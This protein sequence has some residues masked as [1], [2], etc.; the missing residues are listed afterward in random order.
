MSQRINWWLIPDL[1]WPRT[2]GMGCASRILLALMS[3]LLSQAAW[4]A[5]NL[6]GTSSTV[7]TVSAEQD[8]GYLNSRS[9]TFDRLEPQ[10]SSMSIPMYGDSITEAMDASQIGPHVVLM[11][12]NG[13]T[14]RDWF[15]RVNR[16]LV[17]GPAVIHSSQ[18]G[19]WALGINDTQYEY[20]TGAPQN[21]PYLVDLAAGWMTGKWV[22]IKILPV[23][24]TMYSG[25]T[26]AQ[27]DAVNAHTQTVFGGRSGFAIVDAKSVLAPSGQLLPA[28]TI[29]GLHLSAAGYAQLYPL[30][31]A[32]LSSLAV[33]Y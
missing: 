12:I 25:V 9:V 14:M 4:A 7:A 33:I 8:L 18:A 17:S 15:G 10:L 13:G 21:P 6:A 1:G 19:I 16:S 31:Q 11:G 32:A 28:Y 23:N 30:I 27:I 29:D 24:E 2:L 26:N 3:L 22:I 5:D 20:Q